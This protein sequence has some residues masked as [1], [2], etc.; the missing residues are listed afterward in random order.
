MSATVFPI[1]HYGGARE[2]VQ[3]VRVGWSQHRLDEDAFGVWVMAHG[4]P[5]VGKGHWTVDDVVRQC[6]GA[7]IADA[8]KHLEA[9]A[10]AGLVAV[11]DDPTNF[12]RSH[13]MDVLFVGL[14]NAPER[15]EGH[16]VGIPG[17]GT[18]A[19]LDPDCYELWQWGSVA[20]TLWH[21]CEVRATVT[22]AHGQ[23]PDP[24]AALT[25]ILGDLRFLISHGC[26]Y[27]DVAG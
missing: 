5:D 1:G 17:L 15:L 16:A 4:L 2:G 13:R 8:V 9:L 10:D 25:E 20:P 22:A 26:A 18:A 12:A 23:A 6:E 3:A 24:M 27:L 21:S 11:V 7:G 14:G 19:V